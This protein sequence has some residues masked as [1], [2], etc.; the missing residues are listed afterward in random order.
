MWYSIWRV[1]SLQTI[2]EFKCTH[3]H[4]KKNLVNKETLYSYNVLIIYQ[5]CCDNIF[6]DH[7]IEK[8]NAIKFS[9]LIYKS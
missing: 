8:F 2:V 3:Y 6:K 7:E 1:I 5:R 4:E 9:N